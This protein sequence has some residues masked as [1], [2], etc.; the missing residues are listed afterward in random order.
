MSRTK[1]VLIG[2][3]LALLVLVVAGYLVA[4]SVLD[5]VSRQALDSISHRGL[6]HGIEITDPSFLQV[7]LS[8]F[9]SA[10]WSSLLAQL[11]FPESETFDSSRTFDVRVD[12]VEI[13]L[14]GGG[15]VRVHANEIEMDSTIPGSKQDGA[16]ID[17]L[18]NDQQ[19]VH[20]DKLSCLLDWQLFKPKVS[21]EETLPVIVNL[22]TSGSAPVDLETQGSIQFVLKEQ[23]VTLQILVVEKEAGKALALQQTDVKKLS[24]LFSEELTAAEVHLIAANPLRAP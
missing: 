8:G 24:E 13:T 1:K 7:S 9:R 3:L 16:E 23:P 11:R 18:T 19:H 5:S 15:Q 22:I 17:G 10:R 14:A 12:S 2:V 4:N 20:F 6:K 21:L